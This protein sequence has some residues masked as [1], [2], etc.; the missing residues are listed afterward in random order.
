LL[1]SD[2]PAEK[3]YETIPNFHHT[4]K[5]YE[6]FIEAVETDALNRA[7]YV[8]AKIEFAVQREKDT[9][10]LVNLIKD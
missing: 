3:F 7:K 10:V 2:F 5:R 1:L 4:Q 9:P 6:S 8:K